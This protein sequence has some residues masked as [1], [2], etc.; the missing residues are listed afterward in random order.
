MN[1]ILLIIFNFTTFF[2][3]AF[4]A[5]CTLYHALFF[6]S[7]HHNSQSILL[8]VVEQPKEWGANIDYGM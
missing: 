4:L 2:T 5:G 3:M 1:I 8:G 7:F 6:P